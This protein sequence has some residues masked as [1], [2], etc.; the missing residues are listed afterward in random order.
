MRNPRIILLD[1]AT[2]ALDTESEKTVL[3]APESAQKGRTSIT[4]AH[5]LSTVKNCDTI[6]VV[7]HGRVVEYGSHDDLLQKKGTYHKL[8]STQ[9][10]VPTKRPLS[11]K[12]HCS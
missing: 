8:W 5:R 10:G 7:N 1:E 12:R 2:S 6:F 4:I 3:T 11:E 9:G